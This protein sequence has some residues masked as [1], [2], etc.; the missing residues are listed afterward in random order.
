MTPPRHVLAPSASL[1][2]ARELLQDHQIRHLP[3]VDRDRLVGVVTLSDL[4]AAEVLLTADPDATMVEG[5]MAR[6][7]YTVGPD[8]PLSEVVSQ[9][10]QR[11]LGSALIVEDGR[12]VGLFTTTDACRVLA[13]VLVAP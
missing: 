11:H 12:L 6:D 3:V 1:T 7:L 2:E 5:L 13:E 4:Y 9:M 10:A 8:A